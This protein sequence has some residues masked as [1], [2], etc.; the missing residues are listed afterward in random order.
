VEVSDTLSISL[1]EK[2]DH[3]NSSIV[4]RPLVVTPYLILNKRC[5]A[6]IV[7]A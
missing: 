5:I 1:I 7:C 4:A 3:Y 2:P 6:D